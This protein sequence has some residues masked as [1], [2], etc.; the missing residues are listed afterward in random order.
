MYVFYKV[1]LANISSIEPIG[2]IVKTVSH[3]FVV[4]VLIFGLVL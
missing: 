4:A 2:L 1:R 3:V